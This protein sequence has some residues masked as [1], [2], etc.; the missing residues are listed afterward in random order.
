MTKPLKQSLAAIEKSGYK[1]GVDV[2]IAMDAATS[3]LWDEEKQLYVFK[4]SDKGN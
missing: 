1:P 3:E 2:A 4:K